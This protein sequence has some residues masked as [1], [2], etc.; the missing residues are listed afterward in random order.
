MTGVFNKS[1]VQNIANTCPAMRSRAI[2]RKIARVFDEELRQHGINSSQFAMLVAIGIS[3]QCRA[4][5]LANL[6]SLSA[7]ATTRSLNILERN[8]WVSSIDRSGKLR[9]IALS[10]T[11]KSLLLSAYSDW[12]KA[13]EKV[14]SEFGSTTF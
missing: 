5:D 1:L 12:E 13:K 7:A 11:G 4:K 3:Q 9:S 10:K 2:S 14:E 6:L 8:G